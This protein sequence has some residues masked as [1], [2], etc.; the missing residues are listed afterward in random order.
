MRAD[1]APAQ[2][3]PMRHDETVMVVCGSVVRAYRAGTGP[4]V[5][6]L[7]GDCEGLDDAR[8]AW[9]PV[10]VALA[11]H[12]RVTAPDLPGFG[13]TPLRATVPT[14]AGYAA[15]LS[16]FLDVCGIQ[17]AGIAG[18]CLG[19]GIALQAAQDLPD[20]VDWAAALCAWRS[21]RPFL[22]DR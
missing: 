20:K 19:A 14:L 9:E 12:A 7:H 2:S 15:W 17:R 16:A 6:L 5:V 11:G 1:G 18:L 3:R 13:G 22:S 21:C 10:W 8:L 4:E